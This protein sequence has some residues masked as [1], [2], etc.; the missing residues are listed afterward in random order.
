MFMALHPTRR[1]FVRWLSPFTGTLICLAFCLRLGAAE[2]QPASHQSLQIQVS[3][4][5]QGIELPG[6]WSPV[7]TGQPA[8]AVVALHGC[9]GLPAKKALLGYQ[10]GRYVRMFN[11]AGISVLYIDS[12]AP[13][14]TVSICSQK[15]G[16]RSITEDVRRLDVYGALRW[17]AAQ[18]GVDATRLGVV[19]WSHG[20]QTA[21]AVNDASVD[22]AP[23]VTARPRAVAAFYPGCRR[24]ERQRSYQPAVPMLVMTGLLD[25]WTPSATC[26]ALAAR[27]HTRWPPPAPTIQHIAYANSY[28]GFDS[29][30]PPRQRDRVGGTA[31]GKATVGGNPDALA[32]SGQALMVFMQAQF[33]LPHSPHP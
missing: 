4:L 17:L 7:K 13:R 1:I 2:A 12:F 5:D 6:Y 22:L 25:D 30:N 14:G 24:F 20:G 16:E 31:S 21:L 10:Q 29:A 18:P 3:S 8:P 32:A 33:Q 11:D 15:P 9:G 27:L 23:G 28:H 19:G 26:A